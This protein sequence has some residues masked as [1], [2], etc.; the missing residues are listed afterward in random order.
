MV[1]RE[2]VVIIEQGNQFIIVDTKSDYPDAIK[3]V[4][5]DKFIGDIIVVLPKPL[6]SLKIDCTR[7][8]KTR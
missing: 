4:E 5:N 2:G 7:L 8:G 1:I 3:Y 6:N